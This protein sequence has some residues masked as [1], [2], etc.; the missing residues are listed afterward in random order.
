MM[1][2]YLVNISNEKIEFENYANLKIISTYF[3]SCDIKFNIV[4]NSINTIMGT[5]FI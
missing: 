4:T 2:Y 1:K 5:Y 3:E